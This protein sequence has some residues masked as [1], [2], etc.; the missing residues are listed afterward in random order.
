MTDAY[1]DNSIK[2]AERRQRG[3]SDAYL[4]KCPSTKLPKE[5]KS[6]ILNNDNK[7]NLIRLLLSEWQKA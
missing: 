2:S 4:V 6:L 3:I 7:T 5:W 1:K